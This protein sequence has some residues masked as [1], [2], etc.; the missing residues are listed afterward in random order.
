MYGAIHVEFQF[1]EFRS[2]LP[3]LRRIYLDSNNKVERLVS[4]EI[5]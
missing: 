4:F 5:E 2:R 1:D 3:I